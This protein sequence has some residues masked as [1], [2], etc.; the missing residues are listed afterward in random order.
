MGFV[1]RLKLREDLTKKTIDNH[2]E[3]LGEGEY[4]TMTG[5]TTYW[6]SDGGGKAMTF[7]EVGGVVKL[8]RAYMS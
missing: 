4:M 7:G 2:I 8:E 3:N 6:I 1:E 5:E